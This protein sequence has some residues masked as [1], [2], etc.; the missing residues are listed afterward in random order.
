MTAVSD[1]GI[2]SQALPGVWKTPLVLAS[3][4]L[5]WLFLLY[6][7]TAGSLVATWARSDTYAH[8]F[9][10]LPVVLWLVWRRRAS[11]RQ[12]QPVPSRRALAMLLLVGLVWLLGHLGLAKAVVQLA[13]VGLL[14]LSVPALFGW[15]LAGKLAFP[16]AFL[17][18]A[19]P[20]GDFLIPPLMDWTARFTVLGLRLS[21]IPVYQDGRHFVIPS[22]SWSVVEACSGLRY[23]IASLVV[24]TL[25]AYLNF[26]SLRRRLAFI[27]LA[28]AVP[29]VA[30]WVRAYL[31][32]MIGHLSGNELAT[33]AD[34]LVYGWLFFGLVVALMFLVG[35]RW[36]A[37]EPPPPRTAAAASPTVPPHRRLEWPAAG[38]VALVVAVPALAG[39]G[40]DQLNL[41]AAP[42]LDRNQKLLAD[43]GWRAVDAGTW[44]WQPASG[45]AD[46]VWDQTFEK[47]GRRVGIHVAYYRNQGYDRKM[48]SA[49]R[50][51]PASGEGDWIVAGLNSRRVGWPDAG[52]RA[53]VAE[54]RPR[55][56]GNPAAGLDLW[57]CFWVAGHWTASPLR[58]QAYV[59]L[60]RLLGLGDDAAVV[61]LYAPAG[62]GKEALPAFSQ[63]AGP[64]LVRLLNETR[65]RR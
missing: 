11:L 55:G 40:L 59:A 26:H 58:A 38:L 44:G 57:Q 12:E 33:G 61:A 9:L 22:G 31:I 60:S 41:A 42:H 47:D 4:L 29:L 24:G 65:N 34:H 35:F 53:V 18:F 51:L 49:A 54:V 52:E 48:A 30:N 10:V 17:F 64:A 6:R 23:L 50:D 45:A 2:A 19:V 63:A 39:H 28:V 16:L 1:Q 32:V 5:A 13:F 27:G 43:A 21:G 3:L 56:P 37:A 14:A 15:R 46:D 36:S 20:L 7:E 62:E 8:G 25:F